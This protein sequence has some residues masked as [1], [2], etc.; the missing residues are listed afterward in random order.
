MELKSLD[1]AFNPPKPHL[2]IA[3]EI[4]T[5]VSSFVFLSF[6]CFRHGA[7]ELEEEERKLQQERSAAFQGSGF[8]L[9]DSEG[10]SAMVSGARPTTRSVEKVLSLS[11]SVSLS[12]SFI[13]LFFSS[14]SVVL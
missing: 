13:G 7:V 3:P 9:G 10:P 1:V 2:P 12:L 4:L 11:L 14:R 5:H 6:V 8:R